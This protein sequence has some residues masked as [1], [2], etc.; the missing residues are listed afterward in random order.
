MCLGAEARAANKA[1]K[2]DYEFKLL[3][4]KA[5]WMQDLSV[6]R[7]EH[8]QYEQGIT[9]SNLA[10]AGAYGDIETKHKQLIGE[11]FQAN[12][13]AW[14]E[15]LEKNTGG[16]LEAAGRTGRSIGRTSALDLAKYLRGTSR[17]AY[18][19][20]QA[21]EELQAAGAQAAGQTRAQ[22]MEMFT[23]VM[24]QKHPDFAPP[25]PVYKNVGMAAFQDA[26]KIGSSV[27]S[28][29]TGFGPAGLDIIPGL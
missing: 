9:A 1:A 21:T 7:A 29:V 17:K 18:A 24:F 5:K 2:R 26:L 22:Q 16:Q 13:A 27:A 6:T 3:K 4:R 25:P 19:L 10:L 8:V 12:E 20:T 23:N 28:M 15:F 11:T 14:Q